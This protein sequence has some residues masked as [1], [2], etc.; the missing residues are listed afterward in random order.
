MA[1]G[2]DGDSELF[3]ATGNQ[4][5]LSG[6]PGKDGTFRLQAESLRAEF[7]PERQHGEKFADGREDAGVGGRI[8]TRRAA[9]GRLV[10]FD[11]LVDVFGAEELFVG[12]RR[13]LRPVK[14]LRESAIQNV[15]DQRGFAR[16]GHASDYRKQAK[17]NGDIHIFEIIGGGADD[18]DRLAVGAA[19]G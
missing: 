11:N 15:I 7:G 18:L 9:D 3:A 4:Q 6:R 8:G 1:L 16:A 19:A 2:R 13:F 14:F 5:F 12:A 10:N 17:G